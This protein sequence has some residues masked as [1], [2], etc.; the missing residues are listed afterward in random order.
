M[1]K[2]KERSQPKTTEQLEDIRSRRNEVMRRYRQKKKNMQAQNLT[3]KQIGG[4]AAAK[5]TARKA[6]KRDHTNRERSEEKL[7]RVQREKAVLRTRVWRLRVKAMKHVNQPDP[8]ANEHEMEHT[9]ENNREFP[10]YSTQRRA[11]KK[12]QISLP[13]TR[14]PKI[15]NK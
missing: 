7:K 2:R 5:K 10:S 15:E 14:R 11:I 12:V 9:D 4:K 1:R 8:S 3:P 6:Q 13:K